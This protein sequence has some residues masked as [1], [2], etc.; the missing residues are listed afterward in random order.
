M[1]KI[2][3][4]N[5]GRL[6]PFFFKHFV[7]S[8]VCHAFVFLFCF[9]VDPFLLEFKK[10]SYKPLFSAIIAMKNTQNGLEMSKIWLMFDY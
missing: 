2:W 10:V 5:V 3:G 4:L 7:I 1:R 6:Q 8:K 9:L